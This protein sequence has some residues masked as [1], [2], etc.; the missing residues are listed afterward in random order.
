MPEPADGSLDPPATAEELESAAAS[1]VTVAELRDFSQHQTGDDA[2][3]DASMDT[4][5]GSQNASLAPN[6]SQQS[7]DPRGPAAAAPQVPAGPPAPTGP[8]PSPGA[9]KTSADGTITETVLYEPTAGG[10][11]IY[12][13]AHFPKACRVMPSVAISAFYE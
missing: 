13:T 6:G 8:P 9:R 5:T 11:G 7:P 4:Q 2:E 10:G 12:V 1:G 3:I